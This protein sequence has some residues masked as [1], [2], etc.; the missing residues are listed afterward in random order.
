[1]AI[2]RLS[3]YSVKNNL[4]KY[5]FLKDSSIPPVYSGQSVSGGTG[6]TN[7]SNQWSNTY[8]SSIAK[9]SSTFEWSCSNQGTYY[10]GN[11][12][13]SLGGTAGFGYTLNSGNPIPPGTYS[14]SGT[15]Y[16][17][18]DAGGDSHDGMPLWVTTSSKKELIVMTKRLP[19]A[20]NTQI[21]KSGT[22]TL[23]T[24]DV[25]RL[26]WHV[27]DGSSA[28]AMGGRVYDFVVNKIA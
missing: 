6:Y 10:G 9:S 7:E 23:Y 22:F 5:N 15:H 24:T 21:T 8:D 19:D 26:V 1:M 20:K 27:Y 4:K 13:G 18:W 11:Q 2:S 12:S 14:Y 3:T 28:T 16:L 17:Y 25:V